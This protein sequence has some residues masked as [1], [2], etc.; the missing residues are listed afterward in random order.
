MAGGLEGR[1]QLEHHEG[2]YVK[3]V[4]EAEA[5]LHL[6]LSKFYKTI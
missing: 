1:A 5:N 6:V 2:V 4:K 3:Y